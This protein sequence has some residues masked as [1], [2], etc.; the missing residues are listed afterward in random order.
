[1]LPSSRRADAAPARE[2]IADLG[3]AGEPP[4]PVARRDH[5]LDVVGLDLGLGL[6][7]AQ[8]APDDLAAGARVPQPQPDGEQQQ[9]HHHPA[10]DHDER[11]H[12]PSLSRHLARGKD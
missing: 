10:D 1:L 12:P 7:V 5:L 2:L 9:H 3:L 11:I 6:F 8:R 4:A